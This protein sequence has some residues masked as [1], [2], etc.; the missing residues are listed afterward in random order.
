MVAK[1]AG[2]SSRPRPAKTRRAASVKMPSVS[3]RVPSRSKTTARTSRGPPSALDAAL[4]GVDVG[5]L[6]VLDRQ[7]RQVA[8]AVVVGGSGLGLHQGSD[9]GGVELHGV[10]GRRRR[11]LA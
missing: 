2:S 3:M 11:R 9:V 1:N 4:I 8:V 10:L 7:G 5:E 6:V